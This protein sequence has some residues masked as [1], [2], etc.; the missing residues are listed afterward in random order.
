MDETLSFLLS[1]RKVVVFKYVGCQVLR[2]TVHINIFVSQTAIKIKIKKILE[3][4]L[5]LSKVAGNRNNNLP[6][7]Q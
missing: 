6:A 2:Q 3:D 1:E 7:I 5:N 4:I